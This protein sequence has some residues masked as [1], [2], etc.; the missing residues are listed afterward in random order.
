MGKNYYL[1]IIDYYSRW[2]E[3]IKLKN[4]TSDSVIECLKEIF[5]R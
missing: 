2:I 4:K 3:I 5:G 1:I